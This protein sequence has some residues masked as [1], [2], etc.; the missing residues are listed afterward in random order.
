MGPTGFLPSSNDPDLGQKPLDEIREAF[1]LQAEGLILGGVDALLIETSQDILEVKLIIEACHNAIEKTGKKVPIISNTTLDQYGKMLLG[2]NIQSAYT[3]VS[4]M[5]IDVFGLNCST[6]P[7]EMN[8]S[9]RWL[10]EQN[11]H[12]LL[13]VPNAGMPENQ[14]GKAVYKMTPEMM[15]DA[16]GDFLNQYKKVRIIGGCC[17]TNPEHIKV[18]RKVIDEKANSLKG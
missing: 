6:G 16:L 5:G 1:E 2:T 9:I 15:G 4:D 11:E 18:L 3:T 7:I 17:G 12:S 10:D 14:G 13:V 8:P